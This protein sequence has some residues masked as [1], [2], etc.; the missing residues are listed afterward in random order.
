ML[1][2]N[3]VAAAV[4][5]VLGCASFSTQAT[6]WVTTIDAAGYGGSTGTITFDDWGFSD[7]LNGRDAT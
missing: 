5:I 7:T 2:N 3:I 6:E 4:A 1:K